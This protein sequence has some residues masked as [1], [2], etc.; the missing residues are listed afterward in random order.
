MFTIFEKKILG[1]KYK[2]QDVSS[3]YLKCTCC[4]ELK[5]LENYYKFKGYYMYKCKSCYSKMHK[6]T[7]KHK[8]RKIKIIS[9]EQSLFNQ[10]L[11]TCNMCGEIKRFEF[12]Q[13]KS[14]KKLVSAKCNVCVN[15]SS[16]ENRKKRYQ[17]NP[18]LLEKRK[19]SM[20]KTTQEYFKKNKEKLKEYNKRYNQKKS[21]Q[22]RLIREEKKQIKLKELEIKK[23]KRRIVLE[24]NK[25]IREEKK[26]QIIKRKEYYNS[27]EY[28]T[29]KQQK[30]K[31]RQY[32]KWKRRWNEDEMFAMKTRLRN[33][34]RNS[35][36]RQ[37]YKKF[38]ESTESIVGINYDEFKKYLE[39]IFLD[40]MTWDNR[41]EW[42]IDHIIPLSS[43]K[44]KEDLI[45][46][47][48]YTNLQPLWAKDN[49]K[50]GSKII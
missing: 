11:K 26:E 50:K 45:K 15:K 39:L 38:N 34:I 46:L 44:S 24:E 33:L 35:F 9:P 49:L 42:H 23:E 16:N 2:L 12:F 7:Y 25:K 8:E 48:H 37:G 36:R 5:P 18:E 27:E 17:L 28:R 19:E 13:N 41:G 40:G 3:G 43:A 6:E 29:I 20:R 21:E 1:K 10:G 14:P 32:K 30:N 47:C 22:K 31:E 4:G